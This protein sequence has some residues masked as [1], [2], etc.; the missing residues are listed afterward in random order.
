MFQK[1]LLN[2]ILKQDSF[3]G[4][5]IK[6]INSPFF[7]NYRTEYFYYVCMISNLKILIMKK[8]GFYAYAL[9]IIFLFS[10]DLLFSQSALT[11]E[12]AINYNDELIEEELLVIDK[13]NKLTDALSTYDPKKIEPALNAA[14]V[15]VDK[16]IKAIEELG[17]FDGDTEFVDACSELFK[18]FK[19]QLNN[20]YARQLEIYKLPM[21]KYTAAEE[22]EY[23]ELN[24]LI[25]EKYYYVFEKF[26]AVQEKFADKW[27]F[28][29]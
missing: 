4:E 18:V 22:K 7:D 12:D 16:S 17:G 3:K 29:L 14:E 11:T 6:I 19:S 20:E 1:L 9:F 2:R 21:D 26:I 27:N 23:N 8:K 5:L 10:Q 24:R 15:Q 28:D 25:D 13:I